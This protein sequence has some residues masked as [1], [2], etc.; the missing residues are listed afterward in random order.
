MTLLL[1]NLPTETAI[2]ARSVYTAY[3]INSMEK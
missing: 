2:E 3:L 1:Y